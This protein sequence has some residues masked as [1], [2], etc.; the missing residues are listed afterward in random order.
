MRFHHSALAFCGGVAVVL[1]TSAPV[2]AQTPPSPT[3][4]QLVALF[5][6]WRAFEEPPR[7]AGAPDYTAATNARRL[8]QLGVLQ[9][10]L[11]AID[12]AGWTV[13]EQVDYHLVRA[14][15]NGMLYH[16]TVLQ[17]FARDP[18][19]YA[20]VRTAESDTPAEEGPTIHGAVRGYRVIAGSTAGR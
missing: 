13:P 20:S 12:T 2:R 1:L 8:E 4:A 3:Y 16:L 19:Y 10:R 18:A 14:E 17:P 7:L 9:R 11:A 15:M 5:A 6:E